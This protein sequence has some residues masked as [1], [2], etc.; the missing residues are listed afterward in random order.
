[1]RWC[2]N[3]PHFSVLPP[4]PPRHVAPC[5]VCAST[6]CVQIGSTRN[7][8]K[9][10]QQSQSDTGIASYDGGH[11]SPS[12]PSFQSKEFLFEDGTRRLIFSWERSP[13]Y[14]AEL[15]DLNCTLFLKW[16]KAFG[17]LAQGFLFVFQRCVLCSEILPLNPQLCSYF[18]IYPTQRCSCCAQFYTLSPHLFFNSSF[19]ITFHTT[20]R[21]MQQ[22][23]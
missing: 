11:Q 7:S 20:L 2:S 8:D 21:K 10:N 5:T 22:K 18:N 3:T 19:E 6:K 13:V 15:A 9:K 17:Y 23:L 1:M 4:I 12:S 14:S 16:G